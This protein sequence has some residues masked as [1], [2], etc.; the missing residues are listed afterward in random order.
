[1]VVKIYFDF[2][3]HLF[4]YG[5]VKVTIYTNKL[6]S[7]YVLNLLTCNSFFTGQTYGSIHDGVVYHA[8]MQSKE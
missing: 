4:H 2:L 5:T 1:M 8:I 7:S 6:Q 3:N